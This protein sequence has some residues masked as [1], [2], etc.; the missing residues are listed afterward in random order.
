MNARI[1]VVDDE[2]DLEELIQQKFRHQTH[3]GEDQFH[4]EDLHVRDQDRVS[5]H[6]RSRSSGY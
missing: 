1:L 4:D 3:D 2:P 6:N 5:V